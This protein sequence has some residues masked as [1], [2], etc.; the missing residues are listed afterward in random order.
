MST[1]ADQIALLLERLA[2]GDEEALG[3]LFDFY[4]QSLRQEVARELAGDPRLAARF[5]ASDVVQEVFLDAQKQLGWFQA[6]GSR[7]GFWPWLR[8]LARE[9]RLKFLRDNLDA[10]CRTAKRQQALP[11]DSWKHPP[12]P[13]ESP[14]TAARDAEE[15]ERLRGALQRL[16]PEDQEI[17]RLRVLE[18]RTNPEVAAQLRVTP[19]AVAKRLERALRRLREVVAAETPADERAAP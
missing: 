8:S 7:I 15:A 18:G 6:N 9:R 13:E 16:R 5:D 14:S 11:D 17:I 2:H 10:Q 1:T 4:R 12:S 19:A 3:A